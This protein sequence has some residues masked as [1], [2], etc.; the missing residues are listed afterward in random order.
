M[1]KKAF[2]KVAIALLDDEEGICEPGYEAMYD[3]LDNDIKR[4]VNATNGRFYLKEGAAE[5]LNKHNRKER[6]RA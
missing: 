6:K 3:L 1:T 2:R 5:A 4:L